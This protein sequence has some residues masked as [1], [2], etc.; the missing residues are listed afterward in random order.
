MKI[1]NKPLIFSQFSNL[2]AAESTRR[3]GVS[4]TPF[5]SLNLG[6]NTDD[7]L[8]NVCKN[9]RVFFEQLGIS[10]T[11]FASS[12]QVHG[13]KVQVVTA[14]GR[15]EGFDALITNQPNV[16]VGVTVADCTP[17]LVYDTQR[18]AVGA[19]HAGWRGT[20]AQIVLKTLQTMQAVYGTQP[21]HCYA[22]IGTCIDVC[23]FEVGEEVSEQFS[24]EFKRFDTTLE[25]YLIDLKKANAAQLEAFGVPTSQIEISSFSTVTHNEYYFSYRLE[26]GQTGRMLAVI[27]VNK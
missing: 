24:N 10:E 27:G 12:Y 7:K 3:G 13:D 9:R 25:K 11:Q 16:F 15:S 6:I 18:Q 23:S 14:P 2:V 20:V 1:V 19:I 22:Y 5:A 26:K 17:I 21:A 4:K 8:E